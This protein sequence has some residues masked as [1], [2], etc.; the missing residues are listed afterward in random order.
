MKFISFWKWF[1]RGSGMKPGWKKCIDIWLLFHLFVGIVL[2]FAV[3]VSLSEAANTVLLPLVGILIGLTFSWAGN[4]QALLE[5][6]EIIKLSSF[7]EG[8]F[9]D[10]VYNFQLAILIIL[11]TT[12]LW[13]LAGLGIFQNFKCSN[14]FYIN[15]LIKLFYFTIT[16][17]TIRECWHVVLGAQ[18]MI[19]FKKEIKEQMKS[20]ND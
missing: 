7:H 13:G 1:I 2:A 4:A 10:Y 12:T 20:K 19:L 16:S 9:A 11:S 14:T 6:D 17:M 18:W 15:W 8:G 3:P 5:S